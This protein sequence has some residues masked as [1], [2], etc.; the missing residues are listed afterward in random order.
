[1]KLY[2]DTSWWLAC[3][4]R[5][6]KNHELAASLFDAHPDVEVVWTPW[7]RVEVFNSFR[8]AERYGLLGRGESQPLLNSLQQE[9]KLGYWPH[10]EFDWTNA[11]RFAGEISAKHSVSMVLRGM[12][13]FHV[14]IAHEI[15]ADAFI[16][17]DEDQVA[18]AKVSGLKLLKLPKLKR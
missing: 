10:V 4:C 13:L 6:D 12:D 2:A 16:S 17:F 3:K 14:A 18:V 7:Q 8:Q 15:A 11:I 1:M 5:L 9:I